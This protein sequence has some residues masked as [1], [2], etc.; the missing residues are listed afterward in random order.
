[1]LRHR[2][3]VNDHSQGEG[4]THMFSIP[5]AE[6]VHPSSK[7]Q[8]LNPSEDFWEMMRMCYKDFFSTKYG[9]Y[10]GIGFTCGR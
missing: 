2:L 10:L 5:E 8:G 9:E 1:M 3:T 7:N 4:D 6:D